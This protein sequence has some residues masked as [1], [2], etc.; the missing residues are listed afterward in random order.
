MTADRRW[1]MSAWEGVT[2]LCYPVG[3][4]GAASRQYERS[5]PRDQGPPPMTSRS[6]KAFTSG[7]SGAARD[8]TGSPAAR[9]SGRIAP[10]PPTA[11]IC[12]RSAS[13]SVAYTPCGTVAHGGTASALPSTCPASRQRGWRTAG[14]YSRR[15]PARPTERTQKS[16]LPARPGCRGGGLSPW[17]V[18][19]LTVTSRDGA[20]LSPRRVMTTGRC[21]G[22]TSNA[23][24][25][26]VLIDLK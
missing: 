17:W 23:G 10:S 24:D 6:A 7:R 16:R 19:L 20:Q 9:P 2:A 1:K 13:G 12:V 21:L 5:G 25:L 18:P 4:A 11:R 15:Q 14:P 8:S 3:D 22:T 26:F